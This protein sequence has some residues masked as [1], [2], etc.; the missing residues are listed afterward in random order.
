MITPA[1]LLGIAPSANRALIEALAPAL[2]RE[3]PAANITTPLRVAHFLAQA[4][5]ETDGFRTLTEYG[6]I[7]YFLRYE[8]RSDLG[9]LH[10]GDGARY[11]GRGIFQLTGRYNYRTI[12]AKLGI[13]LE[14]HPELA[15]DPE[16]SVQIA[17]LYWNDRNLSPLADQDNIEAI[18]KRI[19]GGSLGLQSRRI[20]LARAKHQLEDLPPI[21]PR[22]PDA[23]PTPAPT[24]SR[25]PLIIGAITIGAVILVLLTQLL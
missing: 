13:D 25:I 4:A 2:A 15:A 1:R 19:N 22:R 9:N 8:N 12:G 5:H 6:D 14:A 24:P 23:P 20:Y 21:P 7:H 18:T 17:C 11:H 10:P 3:L 16:I